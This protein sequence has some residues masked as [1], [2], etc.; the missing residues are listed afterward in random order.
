MNDQMFDTF[1]KAAESSLHMQQ[2]MFRQWPSMPLHPAAVSAEWFQTLQ[3]R[4]VE[5][6]TDSLSKHRE[7]LDSIYRSGI[8]VFEQS[9]R[10]SEA[11]SPE[12]Y[13]R[14]VEELWRK[15][16]AMYKDQSETQIREFQK[17]VEKWF[18]L[19]AKPKV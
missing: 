17:G 18:D 5:I 14:M 15:V 3:K 16:F 11:K 10:L 19:V 6:V 8:E 1:Y 7:S 9:L 2:E 13:R 12:D 4:W